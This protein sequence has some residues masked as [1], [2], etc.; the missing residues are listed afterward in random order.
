MHLKKNVF[1]N[2]IGLL[3]ETSSK[4][5]DTLKSRQDL[6][7]MEIRKDLHPI[8]KGNGRYE[9]P[10]A[11]YNLT[12]DEK[13]AMCESLRGIRVPSRFS[14]NIKKLV[15]M[16]DLSL[17]RYNCHDCHV[18]LTVFLPIAIRAI[19]PVYV[20]M[21]ITRLCYF[22]NK[23]SQKVINEDELNDL[24]EFIGETMAQLEM[25]FPP[26]YF[27][28][29]EHLMIHMV[30]QIRALGPLYLYEM[31][32]Y[33]HFMSILNL[34]VLNRAYPEGSM[35]EGYSTEEVIECCLDYLNDKV[36]ISL[37]VPRF[38]GRLEGVGTIGGKTFI[39]KGFERSATSTL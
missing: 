8:E 18:L 27:D 6:V 26:G 9:L 19:K 4:T 36:S 22:F 21:V 13:K 25:C 11:S 10:P 12:H 5:K 14:S 34:Y 39:D 31:W 32:T 16:K 15:S 24:Q 30:D 28:I 1:G 29:T 23:I 33:E 37:S 38:F 2:T 20:K 7:A 17:C 35:I 3:L